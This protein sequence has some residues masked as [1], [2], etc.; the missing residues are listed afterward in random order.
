MAIAGVLAMRPEVLVLDEPTAGLDPKGRADILGLIQAFHANSA[1]TGVMV[2]HRMEDV[3][4]LVSRLVV[5]N[6]GT[7]AMDGTPEEIFAKGETLRAIG[8]DVP[9]AVRLADALRERGFSIPK[10]AYLPETLEEAIRKT[11][12]GG[13]VC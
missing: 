8:L 2:S 13:V 9:E 5:M 7:I 12:S 4:R 11:L 6:R 1:T 3:A 10:S